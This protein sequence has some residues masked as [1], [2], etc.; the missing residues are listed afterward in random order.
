[1]S[2][3]HGHAITRPFS[4]LYHATV[5]PTYVWLGNQLGGRAKAGQISHR[6]RL[7]RL[8][9]NAVSI[10][11]IAVAIGLTGWSNFWLSGAMLPEWA[12]YGLGAGIA[13]NMFGWLMGAAANH[14]KIEQYY[15]MEMELHAENDELK[16]AETKLT[17]RS[18]KVAMNAA[19]TLHDINSMMGSATGLV[20]G[21]PEMLAVISVSA[22]SVNPILASTLFLVSRISAVV[23]V[24]CVW[25]TN[26]F[27]LWTYKKSIQEEMNTY[28]QLKNHRCNKFKQIET[29]VDAA[30]LLLGASP[31]KTYSTWVKFRCC[32]ALEGAWVKGKLNEISQSRLV[33]LVQKT[34]SKF[35]HQDGEFSR[36]KLMQIQGAGKPVV[37]VLDSMLL[38]E[39]HLFNT[40]SAFLN[41]EHAAINKTVDTFVGNHLS[42]EQK[43][44]TPMLSYH[45]ERKMIEAGNV[46]ETDNSLG[47]KLNSSGLFKENQGHLNIDTTQESSRVHTAHG[48]VF[49]PYYGTRKIVERVF[50][51]NTSSFKQASTH[52]FE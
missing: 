45:L 30:F 15:D 50:E 10:A 26:Q 43:L 25:G 44:A 21:I 37:S 13:I 42:H 2:H 11:I 8:F 36:D 24:V 31:D 20:T 46:E 19:R 14:L 23:S 18:R 22:Y 16:R 41:K 47:N 6:S 12:V 3:A 34:L 9:A 48:S 17:G 1:M 51:S 38:L 27:R 5:T 52:P 35:T 39:S 28:Y 29:I 40:F 7:I 49:L 33:D 32:K 4:R